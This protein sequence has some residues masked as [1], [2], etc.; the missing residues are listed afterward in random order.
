MSKNPRKKKEKDP[1][2]ELALSIHRG[3]RTRNTRSATPSGFYNEVDLF[4]KTNP[5]SKIEEELTT[6]IIAFNSTVSQN[7]SVIIYSM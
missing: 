2:R 1:D 3:Q 7:T 6:E 5:K 4:G